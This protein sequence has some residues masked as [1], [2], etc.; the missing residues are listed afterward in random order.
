M[1]APTTIDLLMGLVQTALVGA[2]D[3][4]SRVFVPDDWPTWSGEYPLLLVQCA[5]ERKE[6]IGRGSAPEFT[7]T[8]TLRITARASAPAQAGDAGAAVVEA[9]AWRLKRQIEIAVIN[10][11]PVM[12][13][14]QQYPFVESQIKVSAEGETHVG[15]MTM[16]LGLEWYEGAEA[17]AQPVTTQFT[18]LNISV[19]LQNRF[20]PSG[21]YV[22]DFP[23]TVPPAPRTTGPDGRDEGRLVIDLP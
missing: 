23:Y 16:A 19:D 4:G 18:G 22:P 11:T 21:T 10:A 13:L 2:T 9:A 5:H 15:E 8:G 12:S 17:F 14:I 20:D 1:T 7:T 6:S 3:A